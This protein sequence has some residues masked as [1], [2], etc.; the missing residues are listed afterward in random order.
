M[1]SLRPWYLIAAMM[2]LWLVGVS[3]L[4]SGCSTMMVLRQ[5]S[6][7]D[8]AGELS[9]QAD[10]DALQMLWVAMYSAQFRAMLN[11]HSVTYPLAIAKFLLSCLLVLASVSAMNGRRGARGLAL[12]AIA[13]NALLALVDFALTRSVR[14]EWIEAVGRASELLPVAKAGARREDVEAQ[15]ALLSMMRSRQFWY[16][17][18]RA[19]LVLLET[20]IFGSAFL[21][22]S[23]ART[24]RFFEASEK[25]LE[26][27]ED[28]N[29]DEP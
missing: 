14:A 10:G 1:A 25:L 8:V 23:R 2:L 12:Q 18:E 6:V 21:A 24:K 15:Q 29:E 17:V 4:M 20:A 26:A 5:N 19:R 16:W 13:A 9:K 28:R 27:E 3:G 7:A 22:L 11:A